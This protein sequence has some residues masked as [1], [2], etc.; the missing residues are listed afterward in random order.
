[1]LK[2]TSGQIKGKR[3]KTQKGCQ[4]RPTL[5]KTRDALFNVLQSRYQ[6]EEFE[7]YDLFSGSGAL[8]FEAYSRGVP[9]VFFFENNRQSYHLI[10]ENINALS[11]RSSCIAYHTDS[12]QWLRKQKWQ[13]GQKLFLVDPP[14]NSQLAQETIKALAAKTNSLTNNVLVIETEKNVAFNYP[15]SFHL[16]QQKKFGKTRLDFIEF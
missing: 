12:L 5:E 9:K 11:L 3:L 13:S 16:F 15:E 4:T 10:N 1:M 14:Y 8:G 6:L 2:I 7:A